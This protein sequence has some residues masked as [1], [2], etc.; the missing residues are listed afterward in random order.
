[1]KKAK[2]VKKNMVENEIQHEQWKEALFKRSSSGMEWKFFPV[3]AMRYM[4]YMWI[5][6]NCR[7]LIQIVNSRQSHAHAGIWA[8][9]NRLVEGGG[10]KLRIWRHSQQFFTNKAML[11]PLGQIINN[12]FVWFSYSSFKM[13]TLKDQS[14]SMALLVPPWS[15]LGWYKYLTLMSGGNFFSFKPTG[16]E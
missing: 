1:M 3:R 10:R 7:L 12:R 8:Q 5:R 6:C 4:A 11:R 15:F 2:G 13:A 14:G 9:R 16:L